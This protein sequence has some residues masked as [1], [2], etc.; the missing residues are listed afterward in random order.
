MVSIGG[1]LL[2]GSA[3]HSQPLLSHRQPQRLEI[4][5]LSFP[6][7]VKAG[8]GRVIHVFTMRQK[9]LGGL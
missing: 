8:G 1:T 6:A 9:L 5:T 3:D 4:Q 2:V 7:L